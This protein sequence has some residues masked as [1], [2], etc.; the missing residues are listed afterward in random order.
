MITFRFCFQLGGPLISD[1]KVLVGIVSW[2]IPCGRGY[3]DV[4]TRV[5]SHIDWVQ[6]EI[7]NQSENENENEIKFEFQF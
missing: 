2:G 3:P 4:Y 7:E 6:S 1:D 5:Y